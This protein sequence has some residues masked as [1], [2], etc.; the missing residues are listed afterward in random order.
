MQCGQ[1]PGR[2]D[3]KDRARVI[4]AAA[5]RHAVEI[6][7]AALEEAGDRGGSVIAAR[8]VVQGRQ[9]ARRCDPEHCAAVVSAPLRR[10][11]VES[12]VTGLDKPGFRDPAV[13]ASGEAVEPGPHDVVCDGVTAA[14]DK[15]DEHNGRQNPEIGHD[16]F[17][18]YS[19]LSKPFSRRECRGY[20]VS[21]GWKNRLSRT[22]DK[23]AAHRLR[24]SAWKIRQLRCGCTA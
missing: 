12:A 16:V 3:L 18:D 6:A 15:S 14:T 11:A 19:A 10:R 23:V 22:L 24:W 8:E 4:D 21:T 20:F 17:L 1:C 5:R 9:R 13:G 2:R 7:V